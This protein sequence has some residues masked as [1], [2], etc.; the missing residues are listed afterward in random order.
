MRDK[1]WLLVVG[2]WLLDTE[3]GDARHEPRLVMSISSLT[4][5]G[6]VRPEE[7]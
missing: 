6:P 4:K 1:Y 3:G 2:Y 7:E 5:F